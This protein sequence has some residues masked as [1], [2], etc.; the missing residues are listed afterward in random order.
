[1]GGNIPTQDSYFYT[2]P[3]VNL[4]MVLKE[5]PVYVFLRFPHTLIPKIVYL[6]HSR[7]RP[8]PP[9]W[10][11]RHQ[12]GKHQLCT[13]SWADRQIRPPSWKSW[14]LEP[15]VLERSQFCVLWQPFRNRRSWIAASRK[16]F[17]KGALDLMSA[18]FASKWDINVDLWMHTSEHKQQKGIIQ[19][20][21]ITLL[22]ANLFCFSKMDFFQF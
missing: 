10:C 17:E 16:C 21:S 4:L 7:F 18:C 22:R 8:P 14:P 15:L 13:P 1:M 20:F 6:H 3:L 19:D 5:S 12:Q 2:T 11:T 9:L